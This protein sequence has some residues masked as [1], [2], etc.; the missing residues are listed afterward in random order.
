MTDDADLLEAQGH[1]RRRVLAALVHGRPGGEEVALPRRLRSVV[2]GV[3]LAALVLVGAFIASVVAPRDAVDWD[4]PSLVADTDSGALHLIDDDAPDGP[5]LRPV[6]NATSARLLAGDTSPQQVPGSVVAA[7]PHGPPVGLPTAPPTVPPPGSLLPDGWTACTGRGQGVHL[8]ITE[9]PAARPVTADTGVV[10]DDGARRW[11]V[12]TSRTYDGTTAARRH[13]VAAGTPV[14]RAAAVE[15]DPGWVALFPV[16]GPAAGVEVRIPPTV[17]DG[18]VCAVMERSGEEGTSVALAISPADRTAEPVAPGE[19]AAY[20]A[21]GHGALVRA[22]SGPTQLVAE[23]GRRHPV[24]EAALERLGLAGERPAEVPA[25]WLGL[26]PEG[27]EL[28]TAAARCPL[29]RAPCRE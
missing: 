2:A 1:D 4:G 14:A 10:V 16:G 20:V 27:V 9:V 24:E 19:V 13:P 6:A 5:V 3:V 18:E 25:A 26:L 17:P 29:G 7:S 12:A 28:S 11:L 22:G 23:T 8:D 15:V 21:P